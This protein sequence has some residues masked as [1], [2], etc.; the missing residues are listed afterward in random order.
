MILQGRTALIPPTCFVRSVWS[1]LANLDES[2]VTRLTTINE[3]KPF[4]FFFSFKCFEQKDRRKFHKTV[5]AKKPGK[6]EYAFFM[7]NWF[8]MIHSKYIGLEENFIF[9]CSKFGDDID[10]SCNQKV[11]NKLR[12]HHQF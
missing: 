6:G 4:L 7:G 1:G 2:L 5:L 12:N 9:I 11:R 3:R 8:V 10:H